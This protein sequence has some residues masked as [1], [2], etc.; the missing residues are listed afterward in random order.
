MLFYSDNSRV[1][2]CYHV[3]IFQFCV[4]LGMTALPEEG[5]AF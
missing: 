3:G 1:G 4:D 2:G 5:K